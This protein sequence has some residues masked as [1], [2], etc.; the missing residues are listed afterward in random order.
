MSDHESEHEAE[1]ETEMT[2]L[3]EPTEPTG[4]SLVVK[5]EL[6]SSI[7]EKVGKSEAAVPEE[8]STLKGSKRKL[9]LPTP[10]PNKRARKSK[11]DSA[12]TSKEKLEAAA[13]ELK[14]YTTQP[15][16][17]EWEE[18]NQK[19]GGQPPVWAVD[20][21]HL[22]ESVPNCKMYQSGS[23]AKGGFA[24]AFL[25]SDAPQPR[26]Y[27]DGSVIITR[28]PGGMVR[29]NKDSKEMG[30]TE[31]QNENAVTKG[32]RNTMKMRTPVILVTK[33]N[34]QSMRSKMPHQYCVL[35]LYK[36]THIWYEKQKSK[37][38]KK[39]AKSCIRYRFE[40]LDPYNEP[41][42]FLPEGTQE[43]YPP[44][45][46]G[47]PVVQ[48]CLACA[49]TFQQIYLR[50]WICL[51]KVCENYWKFSTSSGKLTPVDEDLL[52]YD[53][54]FLKQKTTWPQEKSLLFPMEF[55][56]INVTKETR[57][58]DLYS[59]DA[60]NGLVCPNCHG[61]IMRKSFLGWHCETPNCNW[62]HEL[63]LNMPMLASAITGSGPQ[64][65]VTAG[66]T[67]CQD[68]VF[69][70][71]IRVPKPVCANNF[72]MVRY[73]FPVEGC[74][75]VHNIANQTINEA[76]DGPNAMFEELQR[77]DIKLRR[78]KLDSDNRKD[79]K[80]MRS[81]NVNYGFEY[82]F[83]ET[84]GGGNEK[85]AECEAKAIRD[86]R[87]RLNWSRVQI[88]ARDQRKPVNEFDEVQKTYKPLEFNEC[89]I[90]SYFEAQSIGFHDDGE[91]GVG[92][93]VATLSLGDSG[94]MQFRMKKTRYYGRTKAGVYDWEY[95]PIP[96]CIKYEERR[97]KHD[98]IVGKAP[99]T[100]KEQQAYYKKAAEELGLKEFRDNTPIVLELALR[101]GDEAFMMGDLVQK[102]YDHSVS[103][104][105]RLR[106]AL[107]CR[108]I[109]PT[110]SKRR[111][112]QPPEGVSEP[113]TGIYDGS[114]LPRPLDRDNNEIPDD[115]T[116]D[117][118]ENLEGDQDLKGDTKKDTEAM[119]EKAADDGG[120]ENDGVGDGN[121]GEGEVK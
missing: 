72:R 119:A 53:P 18:P 22:C 67:P 82:K 80:W 88:I 21:V 107:T 34:N 117:N 87:T 61:C 111:N 48:T 93:H 70:S 89:L 69:S 75:A 46:L 114:K 92:P 85:F 83:G 108:Y 38:A 7:L 104:Q 24:Y 33:D 14:A 9:S 64:F 96:G 29:E 68:I 36:P 79:P 47:Q 3:T 60:W 5:L 28:A 99:T 25:F 62:K 90:L 37:T 116:W 11:G 86:V 52:K 120:D 20:R 106:F 76:P 4:P 105:G 39:E 45:E 112:K 23:Y 113:D 19:P 63:P 94:T 109:D 26:D 2:G 115:W 95:P 27:L 66:Y 12:G 8:L 6:R 32:L 10:S 81:Q 40:R 71:T 16:K 84:G 100:Y 110:G 74:Y 65:P 44:G 57:G 51:N 55:N 103:H 101:H 49:K 98:G 102:Y 17:V 15:E 1:P 56:K 91:D 13:E 59:R 50:G 42:W 73:D 77:V 78:R 41:A 58:V 43:K 35:G 31:D 121:T 118:D 54:R 30:I 97:K